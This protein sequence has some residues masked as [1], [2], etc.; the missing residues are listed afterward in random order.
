MVEVKLA[1][2]KMLYPSQFVFVVGDKPDSNAAANPQVE[3]SRKIGDRGGPAA[4]D[5]C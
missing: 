4:H 5:S 3:T 1:G 2:V